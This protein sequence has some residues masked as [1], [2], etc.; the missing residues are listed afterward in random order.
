MLD[1]TLNVQWNGASQWL[2]YSRRDL[3][4]VNQLRRWQNEPRSFQKGKHM[5]EKEKFLRKSN[6]VREMICKRLQHDTKNTAQRLMRA[7]FTTLVVSKQADDLL[8]AVAGNQTN[9]ECWIMNCECCQDL[10]SS[11]VDVSTVLSSSGCFSRSLHSYI[12]QYLDLSAW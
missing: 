8:S 6:E 11:P 3:Q 4:P 12:T 5:S 1:R 2:C 7:S 9:I 10:M